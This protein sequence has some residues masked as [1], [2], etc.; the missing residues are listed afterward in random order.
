MKSRAGVALFAA[1]ALLGLIAL[2]IGGAL[3]AFRL[4]ARSSVLAHSDAVL[5][6]DA[7][8]VVNSVMSSARALGLDTLPIGIARTLQ[9]SVPG[10]DGVAATVVAT[11]LTGGVLWLVGEVTAAAPGEGRRRVNVVARWRPLGPMP[12]SPLVAR[13]GVRLAADVTFAADTAGDIDCR[14]T[15][16]ASVTTAPGATVT[17]PVVVT[18]VASAVAS[19][20]S[21]YL[22]SAAGPGVV[23][24]AGDTTITG[25]AFDGI[26]IVGGALTITGP[27]V[28]SGLVI[29]RG[30]I[31][32]VAGGL[33]V[34]GALMSFANSPDGQSAI[35]LRAATIRYSCGAISTVFRRAVPLRPVRARSWAELF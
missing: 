4:A 22:L 31:V 16:A 19:D 11:R 15:P 30:P 28:A 32:A 29:S 17:S 2:L 33:T 10:S 23:R 34:V 14:S 35:E 7:D 12:P 3:A 6:A 27:F 24:V 8:Y 9:P 13:G 26:L 25:G 5:D 21:T 20:S 1:L 18:A